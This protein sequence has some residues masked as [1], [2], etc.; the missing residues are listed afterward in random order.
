MDTD[1]TMAAAAQKDEEEEYPITMEGIGEYLEDFLR[2][3]TL[4]KIIRQ[5]T[6]FVNLENG[7]PG[8]QPVHRYKL[9][10][11]T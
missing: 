3:T 7:S 5:L 2:E 11:L 10:V 9:D 4:F 8:G 6:E 1:I